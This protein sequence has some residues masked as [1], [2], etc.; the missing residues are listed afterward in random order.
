MAIW[1]SSSRRRTEPIATLLVNDDKACFGGRVDFANQD[2]DGKV[3]AR[4][5]RHEWRRILDLVVGT[6][7][8]RMLRA[9]R[10][11]QWHVH[12]DEPNIASGGYGWK[13]ALGDVNNDGKLDVAPGERIR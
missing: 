3:R 12:G 7:G 13:L 4:R 1:K 2:G 11:R 8:G 6:T 5:R 9:P 10:Q